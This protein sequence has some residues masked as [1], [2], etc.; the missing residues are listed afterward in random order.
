MKIPSNRKE[1]SNRL[2]HLLLVTLRASLVKRVDSRKEFVTGV[3]KEVYEALSLDFLTGSITRGL[4][5]PSVKLSQ[6][7]R[8]SY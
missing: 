8:F 4:V 2:Y 7:S 5:F 1:G 6:K 3:G